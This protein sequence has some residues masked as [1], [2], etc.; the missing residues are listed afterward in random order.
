[1]RLEVTCPGAGETPFFCIGNPSDGGECWPRVRGYSPEHGA[2]ATT[3]QPFNV[4]QLFSARGD[5][6]PNSVAVAMNAARLSPGIF[7]SA[8]VVTG[9]PQA[10]YTDA[11]RR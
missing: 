5:M 10:S 2:E 6:S 9:T 1:M 4:G 8:E 7:V 11:T 3:P